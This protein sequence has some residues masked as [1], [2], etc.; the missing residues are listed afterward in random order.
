MFD[1]ISEVWSDYD[2]DEI[3][4]DF[5]VVGGNVT[6]LRSF[7]P[8]I[9]KVDPWAGVGLASTSYYHANLIGTTRLMSNPAGSPVDNVVYT[10]FG[11]RIQGTNHRYGYAG[12][13][14]YQA[15]DFPESPD[16]PIPFLHVGHRYYDPAS[17]R[18]LQRDPIGI[19]GGSNTYEYV[20]NSPTASVDPVGAYPFGGFPNMPG[21][22][23]PPKPRP[24]PAPVWPS[25]VESEQ[26]ARDIATVCTLTIGVISVFG[27]PPG[28]I[29]GG[30]SLVG[31]YWYDYYA[32]RRDELY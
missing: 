32:R 12:A 20:R 25:N 7:E 8:G 11:E 4:G 27:G 6:N 22:P 3:Y 15:H 1:A 26:E 17:G 2:G 21:K 24:K 19:A 30:A 18:F 16:D 14:G 28:W 31:S 10:A 5:E 29:I 9:A 23:R 13:W